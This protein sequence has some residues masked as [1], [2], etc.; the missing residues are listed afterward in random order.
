MRAMMEQELVR[1]ERQYRLLHNE[2]KLSKCRCGWIRFR[3]RVA[4]GSVVQFCL[5]RDCPCFDDRFTLK[6]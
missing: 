2:G 5:N 3:R 4:D 1:F 6:R